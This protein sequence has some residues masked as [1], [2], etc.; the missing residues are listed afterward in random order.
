MLHVGSLDLEAKT[1]RGS[2]QAYVTIL[3]HNEAEAPLSG[4]KVSGSFSGAWSGSVSCTTD[5]GGRC[6]MQSGTIKN[7]NASINFSINDLSRKGYTYTPKAN[8]N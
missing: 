5:P 7:S 6:S 3:V 1:S 2:S 4:V 8:H